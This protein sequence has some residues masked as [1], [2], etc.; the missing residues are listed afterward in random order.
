MYN[1]VPVLVLEA[2]FPLFSSKSGEPCKSLAISKQKL[3]HIAEISGLQ[4]PCVVAVTCTTFILQG[5]HNL[6]KVTCT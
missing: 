3:N 5:A 1:Y 2:I 6:V 4:Q